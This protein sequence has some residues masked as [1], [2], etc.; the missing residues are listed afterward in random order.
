MNYYMKYSNSG[1]VKIYL[2]KEMLLLLLKDFYEIEWKFF[3]IRF[4]LI[5]VYNN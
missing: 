4:C 5:I 3:G 2:K 1:D